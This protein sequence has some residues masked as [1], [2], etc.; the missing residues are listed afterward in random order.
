M[1]NTGMA[2]S[3]RLFWRSHFR[4]T[5]HNVD[6][7]I[8]ADIRVALDMVEADRKGLVDLAAEMIKAY[9]AAIFP[10]DLFAKA[11]ANRALALSTGFCSMIEARNLICAGAILRLQLDTAARFVAGYL[12]ADPHAFAIKVLKGERIDQMQDRMGKK[13]SDKYLITYLSEEYP[14]VVSRYEKTSGYVHFSDTHIHSIFG[15]PDTEARSIKFKIGS[16]DRALPDEVYLSAI[17]AFRAVTEILSRFIAGWTF[18]K[19][20]SENMPALRRLRDEG[21][22]P[23]WPRCDPANATSEF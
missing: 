8:S 5:E 18:T 21:K 14:W 10:F 11:A 1:Q 12:V 4:N 20:N 16:V 13:M 9:G 2:D 7:Q 6:N 15:E 3:I 23:D 17:K 22:L 19:N